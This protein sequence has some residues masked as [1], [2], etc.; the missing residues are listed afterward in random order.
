MFVYKQQALQ[1]IHILQLYRQFY[2]SQF[3]ENKIYV[4]KI[5]LRQAG[6]HNRE[7]VCLS[8]LVYNVSMWR[9]FLLFF[10]LFS[11]LSIVVRAKVDI[12]H[13]IHLQIQIQSVGLLDAR[14]LNIRVNFTS[15]SIYRNNIKL[16]SDSKSN[17]W[18]PFTLT[19]ATWCIMQLIL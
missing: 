14:K 6:I 16:T 11:F 15:T 18:N 10:E 13:R 17:I 2:F 19:V 3:S 7:I 5:I 8:S 1:F 4:K 12:T 9:I